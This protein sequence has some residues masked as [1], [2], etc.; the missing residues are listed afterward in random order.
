MIKPVQILIALLGAV[1]LVFLWVTPAWA[2][3]GFYVAKA[4]ASLYNQASQVII[5]REN[6]RTVLTMAND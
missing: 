5:A 3:C 6:D 2:F 4:D 1:I